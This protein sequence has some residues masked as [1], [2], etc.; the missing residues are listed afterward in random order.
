MSSYHLDRI[1]SPR[2]IAIVGVSPRAQSVGR[3]ILQNVISAGFR[4][5]IHVVS[6]H[7][8]R[9][10]GIAAVNSIAALPEPPDLIVL[11]T[12]PQTVPGLVADAGAKGAAAV[13]IIA[14]G[15]GHGPGSLAHATDQAARAHGVRIIGPN[16]LG[17]IA[18][19]SKL[20]MSFAASMP[21]SGDLALVSQS[22][23]IVA[24]VV[25][26]ARRRAI[27][28]ST[29]ASIGDA[30]DVDFADLLDFLAVD[31]ATRAILLYIESISD[32]RKFM[33]SARA[34][35]RVKPV[36]VIKA[37]RHLQ[38]AKAAATHTGALAG[39]DAVYDAAFRRAGLLRVF[40]LA[41]L[42]DAAETLGLLRPFRGNRLA[43]LTN[44]GGIGV[45][46]VDRLIDM[47]GDLAELSRDT[48]AQLDAVLP[49][50]WSRANP[51]DIIGDA[52]E[53]RY[54]AALEALLADPA[55]DAILVINVPTAL[56]SPSAAARAVAAVANNESKLR[57]PPKPVFAAWIGESEE[58]AAAFSEAGVP[59]Y[60]TEADAIRGFMH[61]ARH[62]DAQKRL[63]E[64]PPSLPDDFSPN[65]AAARQIIA[66]AIDDGRAW[67]D[68]VEATKLFQAYD[69][70]ITPAATAADGDAAAAL[71]APILSAGKTVAVKIHSPDIAHKSD[72]DGVRLSLGDVTAVRTATSEIIARARAARPSAR[73]NGVTVHSMVVRP[74]ARELI[75]GV[76]DDP[77]FGPVI[78]FGHGGTA[79]E[80]IDDKSLA[81]P[82]LDLGIARDL[83]ARTRISR[84]LKAYRNVPAANEEAIA[85]VLV[86][87]AQLVGDIPEIREIDI[88]PLLADFEGVIAVDARIAVAPVEPTLRRGHPRMAI[89]PYPKEW[90]RR[91]TFG[92]N[93]PMLIR[94]VRPE[95][96]PKFVTFLEHVT[97]EDLRLRF[98]APIKEFGHVFI[99]R[100]T[101]IDYERAMA[102]IAVDE[103]S[104]DMLGIVRLHSDAD[105]V[106]GEYAILVRS[107]L[108]GRGLGWQLMRLIIEY[109]RSEGLRRIEGQV[110]AENQ[111]MIE[112]CRHLGFSVTRDPDDLGVF[113]VALELHTG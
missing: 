97:G 100:L 46:A 103:A 108:K 92:Y 102:F 70:S 67:L 27:G 16:C 32:A 89:R 77:T 53:A 69:I 63:M 98:F 104:G 1:F 86:K 18:T 20:N 55:N 65:L 12:P 33:S 66:G 107:D 113:K 54:A 51:V 15:L 109:A 9:V 64:T 59:H 29:I 61:L 80:V 105:Y 44:G 38:G 68:P 49:P 10:D 93:V 17:I 39:V 72:V 4:G 13:V 40:D 41:E 90:V 110:L 101:Q 83:I 30:L 31:R 25:E 19:G 78:L 45:L 71:A 82:P 76:A 48:S 96:E 47:G 21:R 35:S 26:W 36:V 57:F 11:A 7:H 75:M 58:A 42:F 95:D 14:S 22:G 74:K 52:N 24:G 2:S 62:A 91:L 85:L 28:F 87:L 3:T 84:L 60:A 99:A 50:T 81:L 37:G 34:A 88:N 111:Q 106:A 6:P 94:P 112:M 73:I 5:A 56:V 43:I 79:V 23:A 8:P